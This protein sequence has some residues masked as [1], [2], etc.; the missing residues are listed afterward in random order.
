MPK[1]VMKGVVVSRK[2]D[3]TAVVRVDHTSKHPLFGKTLYSS[4]KFYA[5]DEANSVQE[6]DTVWIME[7]K[8][9][10]KLKR[11]VIVTEAQANQA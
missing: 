8:P 3:K 2:A 5:H 11:W 4:K 10:S 9:I 1:K 6:G 7:S